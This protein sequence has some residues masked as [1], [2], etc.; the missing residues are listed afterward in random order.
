MISIISWRQFW[1]GLQII[2]IK[3]KKYDDWPGRQ[4]LEKNLELIEKAAN[5][6]SHILSRISEFTK[7]KP[8]GKFVE[9]HLDQIIAD[10]IELTRPRWHDQALAKGKSIDLVFN[11]EGDLVTTGS[12]SELREV[13]INLINNAVDAINSDARIVIDAR[14][15]ADNMIRITVEDTG[16]G[17]SADT[18]K[19][20]FEPFFTTK[21]D[22]GTGLGLSVTYGIIG[23]HKGTIEVESELGKGTK[24]IIILP[25]RQEIK[26]HINTIMNGSSNEKNR[27][28]LIVDDEEGFRDVLVE[29]LISGGHQ[30][31]AVSNP[32]AALE[33]IN[34]K[35]YDLVITDLGMTGLSGWE[36]ADAIYRD[37]PEM[38]IIMAT[39]WGANLDIENLRVHHVNA[40][41]GKPFKIEEI[42][43]A[44]DK[45]F[46]CSPDEVLVDQI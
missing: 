41:I 2:T 45:V 46:Y 28:I 39:G 40:V 33:M 18:R 8:S 9:I 5:D 10:T 30:A 38:R 43:K 34:S 20:I 25:A 17:M 1:D 22:A 13:F 31:D 37:N 35:K 44:V 6:G 27:S 32:V 19:R 3:I 16:L 4:F 36:L 7:K 12:P 29:I 42:L 23:R 21:G 26:N 15:N 24:F 14:Y 11:H